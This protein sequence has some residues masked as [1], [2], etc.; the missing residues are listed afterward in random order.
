MGWLLPGYTMRE[1]ED[2][3]DRFALC[4]PPDLIELYLT[5]RPAKGYDWRKDFDEIERMLRWPLEGLLFDV[6]HNDLWLAVWGEK[7]FELGDRMNTV[8]H[9]VEQAPKLIPLYSHR[10]LPAHPCEAGNPVFS[11]YQSDII[12][13]G[14]D[15]AHYIDNETRG[16][17][18]REPEAY[19][20]IPFWSDFLA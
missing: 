19:R 4:F 18:A 8:R 16:W 6:E 20:L 1:I 10:Y 5:R 17:S 13:Y 9:L 2:A 11:V 12:Y 3:Q 7:P 14:A 15:L